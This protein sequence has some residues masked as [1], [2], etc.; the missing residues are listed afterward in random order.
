MAAGR[1][2]FVG[3]PKMRLLVNGQPKEFT[4]RRTR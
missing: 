2:A 4:L 3:R 1:P